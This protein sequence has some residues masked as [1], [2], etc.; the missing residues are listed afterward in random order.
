MTAD[1]FGEPPIPGLVYREDFIGAGEHDALVERL[2]AL[3]LAP[4]RFHGW[5]GKRR[6]QSFG[7]RYDFDDA[8][9]LPAEPIPDWLA[10]LRSKAAA[11]VGVEPGDFA[12]VLLAR[13]DPGA[14]I[15]WHR[16][17]PVFD[18]VVGLSLG[19]PDV[20]RFRQ[21]TARGFRRV[22]LPVA[23][24]SAYSL[25]GE[26]RYEWEHRIVPVE[27]LRFSITFRT[28]SDLGRRK[29]AEAGVTL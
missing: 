19:A 7:W 14:G 17:R 20:L 27:A 26:A 18:Q 24:R 12:H 25:S 11:L 15:G 1:L 23:P 21:R 10:P 29:A 6:T 3:D 16:D 4:F 9:F 8:S 28:L 5:T 2:A 13:Y 22:D